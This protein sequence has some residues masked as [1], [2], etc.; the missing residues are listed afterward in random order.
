M[1]TTEIPPTSAPANA[2]ALTAANRSVDVD[3]ATLVYRRFGNAETDAPPLLLLQHFRGNLDNWDPVL[4][5]RLAGDREVILL[6]NRGVGAS[7]GIVPD[8]VEDMARDVLRFVDALGLRQVDVLGFS[9]GGYIAQE[10]ALVRPRLVR[11]IVLAG[12]APQG[13]PRIHRWSDDVYALA[14]PDVP[15]PDGFLRLFFSGSE[16]SR[17]KGMEYFQRIS[18]R[19]VWLSD[20][21]LGLPS[22]P[23]TSCSGEA[24]SV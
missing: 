13:A 10:L 20:S 6:G 4:I 21:A 3:G 16:D 18:A 15:N 14:T 8:N 9:L 5:D 7:T 11:R 12:T 17:A 22:K 2:T 1:S 19:S 23:I 24:R